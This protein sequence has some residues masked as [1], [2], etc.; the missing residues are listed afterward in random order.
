MRKGH[1]TTENFLKFLESPLNFSKSLSI[2][3]KSLLGSFPNFYENFLIFQFLNFL[4]VFNLEVFRGSKTF[5]EHSRSVLN[6]PGLVRN[7]QNFLGA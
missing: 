5:L 7:F 1:E 6:F 3:P 2:S 4:F